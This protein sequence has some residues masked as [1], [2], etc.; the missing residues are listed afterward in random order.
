MWSIETFI[1]GR[2]EFRHKEFATRIF[3]PSRK[4][5]GISDWA[6]IDLICFMMINEIIWTR[7]DSPVTFWSRPKVRAETPVTLSNLQ[8]TLVNAQWT[9]ANWRKSWGY[10]GENTVDSRQLTK[11]LRVYWWKYSGLSPIGESHIGEIRVTEQSTWTMRKVQIKMV[12][13]SQFC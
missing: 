9:F 1:F 4:V 5:N 10:I 3:G 8:V 12:I 2:P 13:E 7:L 11:V 6:Q